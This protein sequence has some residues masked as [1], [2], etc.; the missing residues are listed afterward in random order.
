M[1]KVAYLMSRGARL[2]SEVCRCKSCRYQRFMADD[3]MEPAIII[4]A[5]TGASGS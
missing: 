2:Y 5:V 3:T 1:F 4:L